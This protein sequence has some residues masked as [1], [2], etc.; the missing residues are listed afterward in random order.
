M[1]ELVKTTNA[2]DGVDIY[3]AKLNE[4]GNRRYIVNH[5]FFLPK[6]KFLEDG[7]YMLDSGYIYKSSYLAALEAAEDYNAFRYKSK[8]YKDYLM[9][10]VQD[11]N[12]INNYITKYR[13]SN[14]R[15][16]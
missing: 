14:E 16:I 10:E 1:L 4:N 5:V 13:K 9:F 15:K 12:Q 8:E 2:I 6:G 3:Q 7:R 11:P